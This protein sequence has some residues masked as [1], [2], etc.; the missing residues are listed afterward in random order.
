VKKAKIS[1]EEELFD[2]LRGEKS[3]DSF[4]FICKNGF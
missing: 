2:F 1:L 3:I 4:I